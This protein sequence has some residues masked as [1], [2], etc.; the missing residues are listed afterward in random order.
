MESAFTFWLIK[1]L[2][3]KDEGAVDQDEGEEDAE[4]EGE[5]ETRQKQRKARQLQIKAKSIPSQANRPAKNWQRLID[6]DSTQV[7]VRW[8]S[9]RI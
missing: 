1:S 4:E 3:I 8:R 2:T 9:M 7:A 5:D 6:F